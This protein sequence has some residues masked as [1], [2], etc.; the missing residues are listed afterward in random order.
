MMEGMMSTKSTEILLPCCH[1]YRDCAGNNWEES[2]CI[3]VYYGDIGELSSIEV[4]NESEFAK[5]MRYLLKG[6]T[7]DELISAIK[8]T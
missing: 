1:I 2:F 7:Q 6:K 4:E 5:L 3:D 8:C